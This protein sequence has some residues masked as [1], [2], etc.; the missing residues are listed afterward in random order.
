MKAL[1]TLERWFWSLSPYRVAS[2]AALVYL[3]VWIILYVLVLR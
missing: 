1:R 3:V 2:V